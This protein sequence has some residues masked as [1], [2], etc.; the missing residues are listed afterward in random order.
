MTG[1]VNTDLAAPEKHA[2]D[3]LIVTDLSMAGFEYMS[4]HFI[5][6]RKPWLR[7]SRTCSMLCGGT[8]DALKY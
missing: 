2:Q 5:P 3:E 7:D 4:A 8:G 1:N 6:W